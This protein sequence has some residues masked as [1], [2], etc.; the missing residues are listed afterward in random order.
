M[1]EPKTR[2]QKYSAPALEKGLDILELLSQASEHGLT[3][4]E[5]AEGIGRSKNEIF[6]MMVVLEERGYIERAGG[7]AFQLTRKLGEMIGPRNDTARMLEIA[8]P[9]MAGL[10]RKTMLSNHLWILKDAR[11]QVGARTRASDTYSLALAE[12]A[13]GRVFGSSAGACFLSGLPDAKTR[14]EALRD[15]GEYD[16]S[17]EEYR[18]FDEEVMACRNDGVSVLPSQDVAG[19]LEVSSPLNMPSSAQPVGVVTVPMINASRAG[20]EISTVIARLRDTTAKICDRM[21]FLSV[22][23]INK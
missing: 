13:Q 11:M 20:K 6:R 1:S 9:F 7:D 17:E 12:G 18:P 8:R 4:A 5:I 21:A 10:S 23:Y 15:M 22:F 2:L 19:V 3:Q 14:L 16:V